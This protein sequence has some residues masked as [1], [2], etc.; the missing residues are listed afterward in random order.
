[1][2]VFW[3]SSPGITQEDI[4]NRAEL[5]DIEEPDARI[6]PDANGNFITLHAKF[7]WETCRTYR[8]RVGVES[9]EENGDRWLGAWILDVDADD[10]TYFG[11]IRLVPDAGQFVPFNSL[12]TTPIERAPFASCEDTEP[13]SA[14]FG[15]PTGNLGTMTPDSR[16]SHFPPTTRCGSSRFTLF[17][18]S[19]RHELGVQR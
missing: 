18:T 3:I 14:L 2:V 12:R 10:E 1:M 6:M 5:G 9:I 15:W 17:P 11:R 7:A 8:L 13:V 4:P 19:I 16:N